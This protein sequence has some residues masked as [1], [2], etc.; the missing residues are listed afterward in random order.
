MSSEQCQYLVAPPASVL[1]LMHHHVN[2]KMTKTLTFPPTPHVLA[3][4]DLAPL[5][6]FVLDAV[7]LHAFVQSHRALAP[8]IPQE[9]AKDKTCSRSLT[10]ATE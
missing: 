7:P 4:S 2:I 1:A 8:V 5:L 10:A 3:K 6:L 9:A